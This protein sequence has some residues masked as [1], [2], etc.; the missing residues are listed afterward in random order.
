MKNSLKPYYK[1]G[2][3][4]LYL[5]DCRDILPKLPPHTQHLL[6][7][8]PPYG[9][10]YSS[11]KRKIKVP[12]M[13]GDN[14]IELSRV[15]VK[16]ALK[17]L[18]PGRHLY[19][20]GR[21]S[22]EDLPVTT[23]V[24]LVWDKNNPGMGNMNV[25]W[26]PEHEIIQFGTLC[27]SPANIKKGHGKL[28]ARLRQGSVLRYKNPNKGVARFLHPTQKPTDLIR[29]LIESSS[30]LGESVLDPFVGSGTTLVA[31]IISGRLAV[32]IELEERYAEIAAARADKAI[33]LVEKF[34]GL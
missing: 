29:C 7:A 34:V 28:A 26:G 10:S 32:G 33:D 4:T 21:S 17:I 24:E 9:V 15:G 25:P 16:L 18:K 20:F 13:A 6:I 3:I 30:V 27:N 8:D 11:N 31:A 14:S 2:P 5:G 23:V 12:V 22:L 1:R 19:V